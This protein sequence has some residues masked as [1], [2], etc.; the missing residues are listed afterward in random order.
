MKHIL[1]T[2][3][4]GFIGTHLTNLLK[5][6]NEVAK[7]DIR[8]GNDIFRLT[9]LGRIDVVIHLAALT[10]VRE[11][12]KKPEDYF[13]TNVLGTA[14]ITRL[15]MDERIKLIHLSSAAADAISSSPYAASKRL[16]EALVLDSQRV[17][18]AV[19]FRP[20]NIYGLNPPKDSLFYNFLHDKELH[21]YGNGLDYRDFLNVSDLCHI[22]KAAVDEN[23]SWDEPI[24]VGTGRITSVKE[25]AE[26]FAKYTRKKIVYE[27][28]RGGIPVSVADTTILRKFYKKPFI[29][30][31]EEDIKTLVK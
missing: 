16:S 18:K 4:K 25:I 13:R 12:F 26:L 28:S 27:E 29:T 3:A 17:T 7:W 23:W 24:P 5:E 20:Y 21:V 1:I 15:C 14:H 6:E 19:V 2:G 11:S 31:L 22:I 10:S 9:R 30:N 8:E